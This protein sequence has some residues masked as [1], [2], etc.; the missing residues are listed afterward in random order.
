M[1]NNWLIVISLVIFA[2][3]ILLYW[4]LTRKYGEK[5]YGQKLWKQWSS[6]LY[7]WQGAIFYSMGFTTAMMFLLKWG[8]IIDF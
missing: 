1:E 6:R 2:L 5:V 8:G 3:A 4:M 7:Y